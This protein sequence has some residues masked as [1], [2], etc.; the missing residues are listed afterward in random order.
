MGKQYDRSAEDLGN[1][2]G[3]EHVNLLVED[4]RLATL[5]YISALGLTRDPYM[6]TSVDNMWVNVGARSQFHLPTGKSQKLRG[7]TALVIPGR[8][9]L[10][11]RLTNMKMPLEG[12]QYAFKKHR[13]HIEATCP[14]GNTM[15]CYEP[16]ERFGDM[17]LG[18][19]YVEFDVPVGAAKGI[20]A[21]YA[22]VFDTS[23]H[24][25]GKG[26]HK[27]AHVSVG[28]GQELVFKESAT[29]PAAYD[30]HHIQVYVAN[31]S[32]PHAALA[33]LGLVS[34][35]SNQYQYRF[36]DIVD[37]ESGRKLFQIEHEV[38]S[39]THPM[40]LRPLLNRNPRQTNRAY[41]PGRDGFVPEVEAEELPGRVRFG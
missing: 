36:L 12:T 6:M 31:F 37:P 17:Q 40:Y 21:F 41:V 11:R 13:D 32:R 1:I 23:T 18:M 39:I 15:L 27:A 3:L 35:E 2:V 22:Q 5:F 10:L 16:G 29:P 33:K 20:A 28:K 4:Q 38:R 8:E 9:Q 25:E 7:R 34:E 14:W 26:A 30:G 24:V 19:P